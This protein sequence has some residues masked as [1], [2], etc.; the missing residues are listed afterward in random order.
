MQSSLSLAMVKQH[1]LLEGVT[2]CVLT[3]CQ[4][5]GAECVPF[6]IMEQFLSKRLLSQNIRTRF[7]W[8]AFNVNT[9]LHSKWSLPQYGSLAT[10][11]LSK[12][13]WFGWYTKWP[14]CHYHKSWS[15]QEDVHSLRRLMYT[16]A[17]P[18]LWPVQRVHRPTVPEQRQYG[19]GGRQD[20]M[21]LTQS[22]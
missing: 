11:L 17:G 21:P 8:R 2:D 22:N 7:Q 13:S 12:M 1:Y 10:P 16:Q 19:D 9:V 15:L 20:E 5:H 18:T 3:G 6:L 14:L 4:K